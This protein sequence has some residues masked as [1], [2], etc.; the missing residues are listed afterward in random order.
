MNKFIP[1]K[2]YKTIF[3]I[4]FDL[5]KKENIKNI[6]FDVDN[7]LLKY[8]EDI[9][10]KQVLELIKKIEKMGFNCHLFSNSNSKRINNIKEAFGVFAYTSCKKPL[11]KNYKKVLN[12]FKTEE[13]IFVGDQLMTDV[14]GA[15]RMGFK[16]ILVDSIDKAEP[17][18][19]KV[20][21]LL[22]KRVLKKLGKQQKFKR[23]NYYE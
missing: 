15:K 21:R 2:Y 20:W 7:T 4:N 9:P 19:T 17:F 1:D 11:K 12:Q 3:D 6:F 23:G 16:V 13:C 22:E 8:T 18:T 5:L 14:Y 10:N